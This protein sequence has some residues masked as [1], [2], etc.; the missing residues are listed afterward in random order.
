[1]GLPE[2]EARQ[3]GKN[4]RREQPLH[5]SF[6]CG[7]EKIRIAEGRKKGGEKK[8]RKNTIKTSGAGSAARGQ[9][10]LSGARAAPGKK[11]PKSPILPLFPSPR[12]FILAVREAQRRAAQTRPSASPSASPSFPKIGFI[13]RIYSAAAATGIFLTAN[14]TVRWKGGL[15]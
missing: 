13:P 1:M 15:L 6:V 2:D 10:D 14:K 7:F 8:T 4:V 12:F 11:S 5:A 3:G 9:R